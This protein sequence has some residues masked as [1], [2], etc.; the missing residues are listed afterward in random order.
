MQANVHKTPNLPGG[1]SLRLIRQ[2]FPDRPAFGT[3]VSE[4]LLMRV[5]AGELA[6]T[7]RLHRPGREVAFAKQDRAADG[8][9]AAVA[10]ARAAGF[11]AVVRLAGGRAALFHEGTLAFAWASPAER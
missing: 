5:A 8:F 10:A 9:T 3:A 1:G 2:G 4:A 6:P 7:F 11:D